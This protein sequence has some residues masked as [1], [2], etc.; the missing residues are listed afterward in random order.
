M[1]WRGGRAGV[2]GA[3]PLPEL[4]PVEGASAGAAP[5]EP[6]PVG[7]AGTDTVGRWG[8]SRRSLGGPVG[9]VTTHDSE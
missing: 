9:Q 7:G 2:G 5:G 6:G 8:S 4:L 1:G 3:A